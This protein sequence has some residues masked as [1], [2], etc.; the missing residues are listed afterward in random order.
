MTAVP[1]E[2]QVIV[3]TGPLTS[4]AL[5]EAIAGLFP[6]SRLPELLRRGGPPGHLRERG[7]GQRLV[8]LPV[9]PGDAGLHQLPHGRRRSTRPS[10]RR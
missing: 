2:G 8:C 6:D 9:R 3:A 10:G 7:Y 4:D 1:A 5:A